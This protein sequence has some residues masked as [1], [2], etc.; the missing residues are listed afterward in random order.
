[1]NPFFTR[2]VISALSLSVAAYL[3]PGMHV[4]SIMTLVTAAFLLGIVNAVLR[5]LVIVLTLPA[6]LLTMG[7]F[8]LFINAAM[9][10]LVAWFLPGFT[11]NGVL[12]ALTGW[13]ILWLTGIIGHAVFRA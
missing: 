6:T 8:L 9:L 7:L 2:L 11:I 10:G 1:M 12:P 5:P 13:L 4:D 3:V